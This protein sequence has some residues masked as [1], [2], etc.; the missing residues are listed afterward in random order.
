ML[1]I[2]VYG[3]GRESC[4]GIAEVRDG[5]IHFEKKMSRNDIKEI[6][7]K[8]EFASESGEKIREDSAGKTEPVWKK[9]PDGSLISYDGISNIVALPAELRGKTGKERIKMINGRSYMLFRY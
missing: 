9:R 4:L 1:R 8:I 3:E 7:K 6:P 5:K 2:S